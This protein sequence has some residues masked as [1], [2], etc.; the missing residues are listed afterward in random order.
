MLPFLKIL[1][2]IQVQMQ[3]MTARLAQLQARQ[4]SPSGAFCFRTEARNRIRHVSAKNAEVPGGS[5]G[6]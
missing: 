1:S 5:L 6:V 2:A 3:K 4:R